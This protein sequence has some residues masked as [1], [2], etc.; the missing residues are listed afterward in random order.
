MKH[1]FLTILCGVFLFT[2]AIADEKAPDIKKII[3]KLDRLY[4]S[5]TSYCE[6]TMEIRTRHWKRVLELKAWA[7]G[8]EKSFITIVSPKKDKGISTLRKGNE[9]W[10]F[11]P[12]V[13]KVMKVPPSMMMGSWMGS[14]F[15]NDDIVKESSFLRDYTH[16]LVDPEPGKTD[17]YCVEMLP[18]EQTPTVWGKII[19][20]VRKTDYLPVEQAFYD[21]KG[22]KMRVMH[23]KK[24]KELGGK[25]I[26]SVLEL[27][28]LNKKDHKTVVTYTRARFDIELD[29][30]VFTLRNLKKKRR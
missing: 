6:M 19:T 24:I 30:D 12:K 22:K 29:D 17:V 18:R 4:R 7:Q 16:R 27:V 25:V 10:N 26:P 1:V 21:E 13:N 5:R 8:L 14:D 2:G 23:F 11:F 3:D 9:M 15:T 20:T 28:P